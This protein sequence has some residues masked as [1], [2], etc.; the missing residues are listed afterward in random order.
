MKRYLIIL[1]IIVLILYSCSRDRP[2]RLSKIKGNLNLQIDSIIIKSKG[3]VFK[4]EGDVLLY[5]SID[6]ILL[7]KI[8][9]DTLIDYQ[10][11]KKSVFTPLELFYF[12]STGNKL[13]DIKSQKGILLKDRYIIIA[14]K[15]VK[16][17]LVAENKH[18]KVKTDSL[19]SFYKKYITKAYPLYAEVYDKNMDTLYLI[20][21]A[22]FALLKQDSM[23]IYLKGNVFVKNMLDSSFLK[24]ENLI[25]SYVEDKIVSSSKVFFRTKEGNFIEGEGF[26]SDRNLHKWKILRNIKGKFINVDLE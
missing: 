13:L 8:K 25:Y 14:I 16:L 7:W 10:D 15:D 24:T 22:K 17:N 18:L 26:V 4:A 20:V 21:K 11:K 5:N 6:N 12:D 19:V 3:K 23:K 1:F 9:T 2:K